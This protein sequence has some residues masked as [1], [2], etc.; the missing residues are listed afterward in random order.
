MKNFWTLI[1]AWIFDGRVMCDICHKNIAT[2]K[3]ICSEGG[4]LYCDECAKEIFKDNHATEVKE[5]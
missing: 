4:I 3:E 1:Y 2:T 5:G